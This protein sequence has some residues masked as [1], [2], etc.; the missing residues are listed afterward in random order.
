LEPS[1]AQPNLQAMLQ[2]IELRKVNDERRP[3][4]SRNLE[5]PHLVVPRQTAARGGAR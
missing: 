2:A 1:T 3:V 5:Q 4:V